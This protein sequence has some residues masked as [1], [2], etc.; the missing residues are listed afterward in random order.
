MK[1]LTVFKKINMSKRYLPISAIFFVR[2]NESKY[3]LIRK[4]LLKNRRN[5]KRLS[6][7]KCL[8]QE[9]E[10]NKNACYIKKFY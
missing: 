8:K 9:E 1:K 2:I 3:G 7:C 10:E 5:K 4:F 6:N